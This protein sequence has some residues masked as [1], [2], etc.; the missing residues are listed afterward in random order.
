MPVFFDFKVQ[1]IIFEIKRLKPPIMRRFY[2]IMRWA[3]RSATAP[4]ALLALSRLLPTFAGK[5]LDSE[6]PV[7][8]RYYHT[9]KKKRLESVL[10]RKERDSAF[11][12]ACSISLCSIPNLRFNS[13]TIIP[14]KKTPARGGFFVG[15]LGRNRT[16]TGLLPTDFKSAASTC[17]ATS[18]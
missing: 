16:G 17:S 3:G 9:N 1:K 11:G 14:T 2:K 18:A 7:Q 5:N 12:T 6:P 10:G 8:F 15:A 13:D 4:S